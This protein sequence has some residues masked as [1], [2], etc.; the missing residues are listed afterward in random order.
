MSTPPSHA[1]TDAATVGVLGNGQL[2]R[3]LSLAGLPMGLRFRFFDPTPD[4]PA[5]AAGACVL[6]PFDDLD[7]ADRFARGLTVCTYEFENVP[8]ALARHIERAVPVRPGPRALDVSQDRLAE[9]SLFRTLNIPTPAFLPIDSLDDLRAGIASVGLPGVLKTRRGGYDGKGQQVLR[10]PEDL[11]PAFASLTA[12]LAQDAGGVRS[13]GLI[14]EAFV[15]FT[16]ELSVIAVRSTKGQ[17]AFYPLTLNTHQSG[18]LHTS[19]APLS[20]LSPEMESA[21]HGYARA[22]MEHLDYVGVMALE[23]FDH[24]GRLLA[25]ETAPRVHNSGHW[26]IDG[27]VTSQFENHLRAIMGWPLGSTEAL[28]AC[29]MINIVGQ[30]P[31]TES[32]ASLAGARLHLYDKAPRPGRKLGHI[33]FVERSEADLH[34][35]VNAA[36]DLLARSRSGGA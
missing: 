11:E 23:L 14:L 10:K 26:T 25:N 20:P 28:G 21:A 2:G 7:A 30:S 33:N 19:F 3:M 16:R 1:A 4:A 35:R 12:G 13:A 18:I 22:I 32:L 9:K 27:C 15:P 6:A 17:V 8:A 36:L 31:P 5:C 34:A 24:N 29:A